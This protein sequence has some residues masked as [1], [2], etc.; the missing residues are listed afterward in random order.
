MFGR[1]IKLFSILGFSVRL[2][3]S[4][5]IIAFL[6]TW[7]LAAGFFPANVENLSTA[8]YWWMGVAGVIG[9]FAS[10]IFHE[11]AHSLVARRY[12]LP[13]KG[14]TLFIFGGIAEM[15]EEPRDARTE[16]LMAIAGPVSSVF[17]GIAFYFVHQASLAAGWPVPVVA[18]LSY[19]AMINIVLAVF[20]MIPAFPL[21]GGRVLRAALWH[22]GGNIRSAT[23]ISSTVG[24][25]FGLFLVALGVFSV[26]QGNFLGGIW[27]FL[28][29]LFIRG[30][31]RGSY[32]QLLVRQALEGEPIER[33]MKRDPVAVAP[34]LSLRDLVEDYF[35]RY[36][37]KT[38]PVVRESRLVGCVN[39]SQVKEVPADEWDRHS[40]Q[41]VLRPCSR[42]NTIGP[43]TEAI[44]ALA[45]M[46]RTGT[47]RLMVVDHGDLV[48]MVALKD[49]L[50]FLSVKLEL[51]GEG[52]R[53]DRDRLKA[54]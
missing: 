10:V 29:G 5:I 38:F 52:E 9:L 16:F 22:W 11:L 39:V 34:S 50:D 8:T 53:I 33:F 25:M 21:D 41:E 13:M 45:R 42:E 6:F 7:T 40:V 49:L 23:R 28:I 54:A 30:I 17:L 2:D 20:N 43:D 14:I 19:L 35:Y 1:G 31:A 4:W 12:G 37:F 18:V 36:H 48:G 24:S 46:S 51:D 32:Q 26:F 15:D 44:D 27:Y 47:S 3:P